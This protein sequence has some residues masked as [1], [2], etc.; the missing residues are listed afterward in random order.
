MRTLA[1]AENIRTVKPAVISLGM[2]EATHNPALEGVLV[3]SGISISLAVLAILFNA[4]HLPS[5][6]LF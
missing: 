6:L 5:P 1:L 3:F 4:L 2:P